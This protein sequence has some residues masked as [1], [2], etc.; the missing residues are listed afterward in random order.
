MK[1]LWVFMFDLPMLAL[2]LSH[3]PPPKSS[4]CK[5]APSRWLEALKRQNT[6]ACWE[7]TLVFWSES[8]PETASWDKH[9]NLGNQNKQVF[10]AQ[11]SW[12]VSQSSLKKKVSHELISSTNGDLCLLLVSFSAPLSQSLTL[13]ST[14]NSIHHVAVGQ[15]MSKPNRYLF[16]DGQATF[17]RF[18]KGFLGVH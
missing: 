14:T 13:N 3:D 7:E 1:H 8:Q 15:N 10:W 11:D 6:Q 17:C 9:L 4:P 18:F 16:G 2:T 5:A 12:R